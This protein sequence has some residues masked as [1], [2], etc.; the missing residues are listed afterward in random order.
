[1]TWRL[2]SA[3]LWRIR[4]HLLILLFLG[5]MGALQHSES[6]FFATRLSMAWPLITAFTAITTLGIF[7]SR[8]VRVLPISRCAALRSAWLTALALPVAITT[9]RLVATLA[10]L[11]FGFTV[12]LG[13]EAIALLIVWDTIFIGIS[14]ALMQRPD[15]PW[16]S[17]QQAFANLRRS[18]KLLVHLG[19][20]LAVPF[21][22]PEL[23]PQSLS[24]VTWLHLTGVLVGIVI[25]VWP[26]VTAP[27][28]W[29]TL[30]VL[31][32]A[33]RGTS[34]KPVRTERTP[35][36]LDRL[37]GMRRLL[38]G[39]VGTAALVAVLTLC[40][41]TALTFSLEDVLTP[42]AAEVND[43]AFF[44][45]GGPFFLLILGPVSWGNGLVP[46]LRRLRALPVS[47][48]QIV[49]TMTMLP[50]MMPVFFWTC[51]TA[52]HLVVGVPGETNWRLE[53][54]ALLCG[55][56]AFSG[57][58]HARF[59]S[60]IV[61]LAGCGVPILGVMALMEFFDKVAV[62]PLIAVWFPVIGLVGVP[63]AF[64]LNYRT[65][66]RGS[67][68][69]QVYRPAPGESLYRGGRP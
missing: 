31:Y 19:W 18:A 67:S 33:P 27:D 55:V 44:L 10:K 15:D 64:L 38:P 54:L 11:A 17:V 63:A 49:V 43:M 5:A 25:T 61:M 14:L 35:R 69:S 46:F 3:Q 9:G 23:V 1:M 8:D 12:T 51:A 47:A 4:W 62:E 42:F 22:G 53:S 32:D 58:V 41:S 29:P 66:T 60:V 28:Q 16:E 56:M 36:G 39:P 50:L 57:A 26:L 59:N 7:W 52:V 13:G 6:P 37:T 30:G 65:I 48:M 34:R 2:V 45:I 20:M 24:D 68:S 21:A 40:A